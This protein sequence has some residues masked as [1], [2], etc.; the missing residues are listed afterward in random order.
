MSTNTPIISKG[1]RAYTDSIPTVPTHTAAEEGNPARNKHTGP[2]ARLVLAAL[3]DLRL[4]TALDGVDG[5]SG[6]A[7]FAGHEEDT[8]FFGEEG[9]GR[10]AGFAGDV[11]D[12]G[13]GNE[14]VRIRVRGRRCEESVPM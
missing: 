9:V 11:F 4:E 6:A 7:R 1:A 2:S 5:P 8:V 10:F 3:P 14:N 12:W 13:M